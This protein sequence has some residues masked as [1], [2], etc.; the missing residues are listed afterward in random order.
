MARS[1]RGKGLEVGGVIEGNAENIGEESVSQKR[2]GV[3]ADAVC[4]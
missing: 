3:L 2:V 1:L 4:K